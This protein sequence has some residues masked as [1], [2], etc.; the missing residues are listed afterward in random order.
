MFSSFTWTKT[1]KQRIAI[2][3]KYEPLQPFLFSELSKLIEAET[4]ID[5]GANIGA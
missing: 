5:I 4:F 3:E 2:L 1:G